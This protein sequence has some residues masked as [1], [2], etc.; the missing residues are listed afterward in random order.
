M[1]PQNQERV[2]MV[3][4]IH[5]VVLEVWALVAQFIIPELLALLTLLAAEGQMAVLAAL[6]AA[7]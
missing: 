4:R 7:S 6:A 3:Q 2:V 1:S 5:L